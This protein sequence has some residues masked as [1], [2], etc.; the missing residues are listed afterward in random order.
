[1]KL[2]KLFLYISFIFIIFLGTTNV[3][4]SENVKIKSIDLVDKS[5]ETIETNKATFD[6]LVM[7]FDLKFNELNDYV[8]Y[9]IVIENNES[10]DYKISVDSNFGN[11]KYITYEYEKA[12]NLKAN[13]D[14]EF[15]VTVTYKNEVNN[16]ELVNG[17][18]NEK[19]SAVLNLSNDNLSNPETSNNEFMI[20]IGLVVMIGVLL[21]LFKNEKNRKLSVFVLLG[22][23]SLPLFVKAVDSLKITV[24]SNVEIKKGY[25][26]GYEVGGYIKAADMD[27]FDL[28]HAKCDDVAYDYLIYTFDGSI[29]DENKYIHCYKAFYK[30]NNLYIPGETVTFDP[31]SSEIY[32]INGCGPRQDED[33]NWIVGDDGNDIKF[34]NTIKKINGSMLYYKYDIYDE[35]SYG[36]KHNDDDNTVM[37]FSKAYD[38]WQKNGII[39]VSRGSTFIMPKH[40]VIFTAYPA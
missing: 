4:A 17:K 32:S 2:K 30:G 35:K 14:N 24:N 10:K 22:I 39:S 28:S 1:M 12:D 34:C 36:Y 11:S 16:D 18:Y 25:S 8:K 6:G 21:I 5:D 26:V 29:S 38:T 31:D 27:E 37:K 20:V 40:D 9:K 15:Y 13:S 33:G 7:N 19:N 23:L 3:N